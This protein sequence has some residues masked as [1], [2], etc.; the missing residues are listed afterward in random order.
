MPSNGFLFKIGKTNGTLFPFSDI[1]LR[2]TDTIWMFVLPGTCKEIEGDED[3]Q[4]T[5]KK[6]KGPV[7][8]YSQI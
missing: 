6:R 1:D 2:E 4:R 7:V 8:G 3:V 5:L